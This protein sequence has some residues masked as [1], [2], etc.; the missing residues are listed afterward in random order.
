MP[1]VGCGKSKAAMRKEHGYRPAKGQ[2][3]ARVDNENWNGRV[4]LS[5]DSICRYLNA[6]YHEVMTLSQCP[7]LPRMMLVEAMNDARRMLP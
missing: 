5:F 6:R 4:C 1:L 3:A 7:T 2:H